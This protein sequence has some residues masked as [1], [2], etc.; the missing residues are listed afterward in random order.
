MY[1]ESQT[2]VVAPH[3]ENIMFSGRWEGGLR[4]LSFYIVNRGTGRRQLYL[5]MLALTAL[6]C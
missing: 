1:E 2:S 3:Q 4:V 5:D 6:H